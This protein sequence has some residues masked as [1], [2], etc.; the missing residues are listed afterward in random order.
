[1]T[2][3]LPRYLARQFL[4]LFLFSLMGAV[5]LFVI[6]DLVENVDQFIDGRVPT[7][8][9]ALYYLYFIPFI[10][11]LTM[12]MGTLL[13]TVFSVGVLAKNNEITA[14]KALG[15]SFHQMMRTLLFLGAAVAV[16]NFFL[17]EAVSI[18]A[19]RKKDE[20]KDRYLTGYRHKGASK[21]RNLLIQ[22]PPDRIIAI[23]SFN[24][25]TN[26]AS[27]VR[28]ETF[29]GNRLVHRIDAPVMTWRDKQWRIS[30]GYERF[31][32]GDTER[33]APV[34]LPISFRFQFSP[35]EVATAQVSPDEM[36]FGELRRF[37]RK[38][39]QTRGE[40]QRWQTDLHMRVAFPVSNLLIV[41]LA[42]PLAY[43]RRKKSLAVGFGISLAICFM[44][45][46]CIKL[47]QTLGQNRAIPPLAAAWMGNGLAAVFGAV[48]IHLTRK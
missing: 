28:I 23:D 2:G 21:F 37:I 9:M 11:V 10:A 13:A 38:V 43:N 33:A 27:G 1:M 29:S 3:L 14:M 12:P 16:F 6:V 40:Y 48:S 46:G 47:G 24:P 35:R 25:V 4:G 5:L 42:A 17:N 41:L 22:D 20:I 34:L 15:Y 18:P 7:S 32:S 36:R 44:L 45:F 30:G 31:F 39:R 8:V 19:N 26:S